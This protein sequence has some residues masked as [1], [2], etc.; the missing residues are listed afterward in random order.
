MAADTGH[1][2]TFAVENSSS[3]GTY[4]VVADVQNITLPSVT[5]G[6]VDVTTLA[7]TARKFIG[8][9]P[10]GGEVEITLLYDETVQAQQDLIDSVSDGDTRR[11]VNYQIEFPSG[12]TWT[13]NGIPIDATPAQATHDDAKTLTFRLKLNGG[14]GTVVTA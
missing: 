9:I 7:D 10:E 8:T 5:R 1:S 11:G 6:T 3:P 2:I 12:T 13:F 14:V 4:D